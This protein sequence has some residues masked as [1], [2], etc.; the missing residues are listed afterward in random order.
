LVLL[1]NVLWSLKK[2]RAIFSTNQILNQNPSWLARM[3]FPALDASNMYLIRVLI[4][5][6]CCLLV[7]WLF[8]VIAWVFVLWYA[9]KNRATVACLLPR[10]PYACGKKKQGC[11]GGKSNTAFL[12]QKQL[13][14]RK[15]MFLTVNYENVQRCFVNNWR[16]FPAGNFTKS[17]K[18]QA[19]WECSKQFQHTSCIYEQQKKIQFVR[20]PFDCLKD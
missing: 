3:R 10:A 19:S 17:L 16:Y 14:G 1:Y 13:R 7:L 15:S 11:C 6:M 2:T 12:H 9:I 4:G 20:S 8:R 18:R 5:L